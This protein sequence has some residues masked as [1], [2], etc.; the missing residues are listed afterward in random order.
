LVLV[1]TGFYFQRP[2]LE[3]S[4][5]RDRATLANGTVCVNQN[6]TAKLLH[7]ESLLVVALFCSNSHP[8]GA[9]ELNTTARIQTKTVACSVFS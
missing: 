1:K 3:P 5:S 4:E 6:A 9:S 8:N 7:D 2:A